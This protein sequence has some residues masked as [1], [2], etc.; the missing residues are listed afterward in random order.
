MSHRGH[1]QT[2]AAFRPPGG[3]SQPLA[4]IS[5]LAVED[6]DH[7][8]LAFDHAAAFQIADGDGDAGAADPEYDRQEFVGERYFVIVYPIPVIRSQRA[9]R[10]VMDARPLAR[11]VEAVWTMKTCA[12]RK[13]QRLRDGLRSIAARRTPASTRWPDPPICMK[14]SLGER[15]V[16]SRTGRFA[17]PS[18]PTMPISMAP[19][20]RTEAA[21]EAI[22][23]SRK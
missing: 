5:I 22:P 12:K 11:A 2:G 14:V 19:S 17:R 10:S 3:A 1:H 7:A 20:W 18:R 23:A 16:P 13:R 8:A 21:V 15:S 6:R 4:A 9:R